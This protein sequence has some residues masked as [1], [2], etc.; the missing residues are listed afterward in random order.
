MAKED[1]F[2][3]QIFAH[4][5]TYVNTFQNVQWV[6][7]ADQV[8]IR[9][10]FQHAK[11]IENIIL[12]RQDFEGKLQEWCINIKKITYEKYFFVEAIN[13]LLSSILQSLTPLEQIKVALDEYLL[14]SN[15]QKLN[16]LIHQLVESNALN[17][18]LHESIRNYLHCQEILEYRSISD[19]MRY[20]I[21]DWVFDFEHQQE[22]KLKDTILAGCKNPSYIMQIFNILALN[23]DEDEN[24]SFFD[25]LS[26]VIASQLLIE[27]NS[28]DSELWY[29]L[30]TFEADQL[31]ILCSRYNDL[32]TVILDYMN[33][34]PNQ[35]LLQ[36]ENT[37]KGVVSCWIP[38][39]KA[40]S[41]INYNIVISLV[42]KLTHGAPKNIKM[43]FID[44]FRQWIN[45]DAISF[46]DDL[47]RDADL[48]ELDL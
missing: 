22:H 9:N 32:F 44:K 17:H 12:K 38:K 3:D 24:K 6:K 39:D 40:R 18:C 13:N 4:L 15:V 26:G 41:K 5:N 8:Q 37:R 2:S 27:I 25:F 47:E 16:I 31:R 42:K 11:F 36:S 20:L 28:P 34:L 35:M 46:W 29:S 7:N 48:L 43:T 21:K 23:A 19:R 33:E 14:V 10:A 30:F 45:A 1:N